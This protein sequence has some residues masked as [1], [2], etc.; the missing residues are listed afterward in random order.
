MTKSQSDEI[1]ASWAANADLWARAVREDLIPSRSA[2]TDRAI[3]D[4]VNGLKPQRVVDIG[5]GEGRLL[6][7]LDCH[8]VGVDGSAALVAAAQ[9]A[10][11]GGSYF[12][13]TY[14]DLAAQPDKLGGPYDVAIF[15]FSLLGADVSGLLKAAGVSLVLGGGVLI[16]TLHPWAGRGEAGYQDGWRNETFSAFESDD[17]QPMPWYYRT[18]ASWVK[19][20][21]ASG[22]RVQAIHEPINEVS[23]EPLSV[24]FH[25]VGT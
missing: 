15:N 23:G 20:L 3:I 24:L 19:Q 12:T 8:G 13:L 6:R 16:Q 1:Y 25:C 7:Q 5:C 10:D 11:G 22:L 14:E 21:A 2:G 17:W 9:A 18:M 4:A